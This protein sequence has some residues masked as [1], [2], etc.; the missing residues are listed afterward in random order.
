ME[1]CRVVSTA[2]HSGA[3][4]G[5]GSQTG[6]LRERVQ[7]G[8]A[9]AAASAASSSSARTPSRASARAR[10]SRSRRSSARASPAGMQLGAHVRPS[11][12]RALARRA[13]RAR[14]RRRARPV[15]RASSSPCCAAALMADAGD[16]RRKDAGGARRAPRTM[17]KARRG[18]RDR[19]SPTTTRPGRSC[20]PDRG[21]AARGPAQARER[22]ACAR[23]CSMSPARSTRRRW[24]ARSSRFRA[25]LDARRVSRARGRG[26]LRRHRAAV[27]PTCAPSSRR[28][29]SAPFAGARRWL[30]SPRSAP[31]RSSTS[32]PGRCSRSSCAR[33]LPDGRVLDLRAPSL[34]R[35]QLGRCNGALRRAHAR[36]QRAAFP[37]RAPRALRTAGIVGLGTA[38]PERRRP[39]RARSARASASTT[40]GSSGAP[41]SAS[42]ATPRPGERVSELASAA[43][44]L[45]LED[46]GIDAA[47]DRHGARRDARRR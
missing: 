26:D 18:P 5:Q 38:L 37:A 36:R 28:R 22:S 12:R 10:A 6:D 39:Q 27:Q 41:G 4:P 2:L 42:A 31:R 32:G 24:P 23:S 21:A 40:S 17:P 35:S 44:R 45:A 11:P 43:G 3:V 15:R 7:R 8:A 9:G 46:A 47:R 14:R 20:S 34:T 19:A 33:N 29:S 16:G 1:L 25:A 30:R 13:Q